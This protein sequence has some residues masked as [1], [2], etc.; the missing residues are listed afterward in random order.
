MSNNQ[1]EEYRVKRQIRGC[2]HGVFLDG[3]NEH[4]SHV[5]MLPQRS[6][7]LNQDANGDF[8][9]DEAETILREAEANGFRVG[10][11]VVV[12]FAPCLDEGFFSH[13]EFV[14]LS[15]DLTAL[16]Y[17]SADEQHADDTAARSLSA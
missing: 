14:G 1:S 9:K 7:E 13:F 2:W 4:G 15:T 3:R 12:T 17:G 11:A 16:L 8:L 5:L 6:I 10:D